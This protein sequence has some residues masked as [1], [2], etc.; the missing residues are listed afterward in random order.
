MNTTRLVLCAALIFACGG[1]A[2]SGSVSQT[3]STRDGASTDVVAPKPSD[4]RLAEQ[5]VGTWQAVD[6]KTEQVSLEINYATDGTLTGWFWNHEKTSGGEP[7]DVKVTASARWEV[8]DGRIRVTSAVTEP[9]GRLPASY[10]SAEI[11]SID[12]KD[13]VLRS[14]EDGALYRRHRSVEAAR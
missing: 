5:L 12:A 7:N 3:N 9:A 13:L 4:R 14:S 11:V 6:P 10:A 8:A 2:N 1:C